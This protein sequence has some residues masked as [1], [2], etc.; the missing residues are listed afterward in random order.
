MNGPEA[1]IV[2]VEGPA[3]RV[4]VWPALGGALVS[5]AARQDDRWVEVTRPVDGAARAA[6]DP[7]KLGGFV[8]APFCNRIDG[9]R[10][11][12]AGAE[13]RVPCE[14]PADPSV[15]IHG[16]SWHRPWTVAALARDRLELAQHIDED[17]SAFRYEARLVFDVRRSEAETS[18]SLR[19]AGRDTM[20]YGLGFHPCFRRTPQARV[21]FAAGGWLEPDRR[22][23]P[24][25]WHA[26]TTARDAG[27]GRPV[28]DFAGTDATFTGWQR[29][30][31]LAWPEL[32][33]SLGLEASATAA[34]LH[35]YVP[36]GDP[37]ML[38]LEP[39]S[40]IIDVANRRRFAH[41]GDMTPLAPGAGLA[42][43]MRWR[44]GAAA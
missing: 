43:T 42:M 24:V 18:L 40:H 35:V 28:A 29:T 44:T 36:A 37:R 9:G 25:A 33:L 11:T 1:E 27:A 14:W 12:W 4:R 6:R 23:L 30:A 10:F 16:L 8:M 41:L 2:T 5:A 22:C 39:V 26:L 15:A 19:N 21:T 38:C 32:G 31:V 13:R 7:S 20:P 17:A 34:A 3:W